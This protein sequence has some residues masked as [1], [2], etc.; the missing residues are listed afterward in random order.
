MAVNKTLIEFF[1]A[2]AEQTETSL[3]LIKAA[4]AST[5]TPAAYSPLVASLTNTAEALFLAIL[6]KVYETQDTSQDAEIAIYGPEVS[7]VE[8]V[9][10]G[11]AQPHQQYLFTVRVLN[12]MTVAMPNPNLI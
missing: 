8:I 1:G 12:K 3:T 4:L 6:M 9:S 7:L 5:R 10:D 11:V 2:G